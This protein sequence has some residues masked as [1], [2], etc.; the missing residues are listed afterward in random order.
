MLEFQTAVSRAFFQ[1][2]TKQKM[3]QSWYQ[4]QTLKTKTYFQFLIFLYLVL[5][6]LAAILK[7]DTGLSWL[8]N[9]V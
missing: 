3:R 8:A 5:I 4:A 6:F 7:Q 2:K 9:S 1:I